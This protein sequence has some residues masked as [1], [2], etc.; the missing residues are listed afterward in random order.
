MSHKITE[1]IE[2]NALGRKASNLQL[3]NIPVGY[4]YDEHNA[5]NGRRRNQ[6]LTRT[7]RSLGIELEVKLY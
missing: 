1:M 4:H 7:L 5:H 3:V 6:V 2:G